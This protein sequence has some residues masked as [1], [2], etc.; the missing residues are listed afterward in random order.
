MTYL[1]ILSIPLAALLALPLLG[2][3]EPGDNTTVAVD[4]D[5]TAPAP[6]VIQDTTPPPPPATD[7]NVNVQVDRPE[8]YVVVDQTVRQEHPEVVQVIERHYVAANTNLADAETVFMTDAPGR[9]VWVEEIRYDE[10]TD[11]IY[12]VE[13]MQVRDVAD[14]TATAEVELVVVPEVYLT[15]DPNVAM[16]PAIEARRVTAVYTLQRDAAG[17]EWMVQDIDV[18][19]RTVLSNDEV[20]VV[21]QG[22]GG[23]GGT[24]TVIDGTT[25]DTSTG[26]GTDDSGTT[27]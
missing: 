5:T 9:T 21:M 6:T 26:S 20:R 16:D 12:R 8:E 19:N 10:N 7:V 1:R 11:A 14:T 2:C 23:A 22:W 27:Y 24:A 13:R 4:R 17:Q 18:T 3:P 25:N 15:A